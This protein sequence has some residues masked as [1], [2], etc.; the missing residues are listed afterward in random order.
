MPIQNK[1]AENDLSVSIEE[2]VKF[3]ESKKTEEKYILEKI[4]I[5][6][7]KYVE[8]ITENTDG[9]TTAYC[10]WKAYCKVAKKRGYL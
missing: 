9:A 8:A 4:H 10:W 2:K 1:N 7:N 6:Y 5:N 3:I